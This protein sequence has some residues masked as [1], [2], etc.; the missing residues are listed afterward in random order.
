MSETETFSSNDKE[1]IIRYN[2]RKV[3]RRGERFGVNMEKLSETLDN[4]NSF[5]DITDKRIRIIKKA[6]HL[7]GGIS[8]CQLFSEGN[9]ET[10]LSWTIRFLRKN[11]FDLPIHTTKERKNVYELPK[12][13]SL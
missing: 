6:A 11:N 1:N 2:K 3:E 12:D 7:L 5:N 8:Y 4:V 9:K 13:K 10:A